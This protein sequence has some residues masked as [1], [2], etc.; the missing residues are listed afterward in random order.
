MGMSGTK[1]KL[2]I[3]WASGCGGCEI[4]FANLDERLL[5][6]TAAFDLA[7]CPALVDA[8]R[9]DVEA[10]PDGG[11]AL[12]LFDG[13]IRTSENEEWAALLRRKSRVLVAMGAC[14]HGGGIPALSNLS[15]RADHL[16]TIYLEQAENP[17]GVL[18]SHRVEVPEGTLELPVLHERVRR[19]A[20]VVPVDYALPGCP[21]ETEQLWNVL[22]RFA[23]GD[24][25]PAPGAVLGTGPASVCGECPRRRSER[26]VAAFRRVW[27]FVPDP[28]VC[29]VEQGIACMGLATRGGCGALCPAVQMPCIGCYG[30]PEGV[31]DQAAKMVSALGSVLDIAPIRELRNEAAIAAR[32]D[33]ALDGIPDVAGLTGKFHLAR[34]GRR[35]QGG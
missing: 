14:A 15:T 31:Y 29:L 32:I 34:G 20:D 1:P 6:A 27:E 13:A 7:F 22:R 25:L 18:P 3:Y 4:A 2:A 5:E 35:P 28:E 23:G 19:L 8:K 11:L 33:A 12:T 17:A 9:A 21:P 10:L 26:K 24:P 30:P 16:R